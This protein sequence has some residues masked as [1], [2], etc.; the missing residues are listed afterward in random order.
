[1]EMSS[2]SAS[3]PHVCDH[4]DKRFKLAGDL[5]RH[6]ASVHDIGVV[7]HQCGQCDMRF[8]HASNLKRHLANAHDVGVVW[9]QCDQCDKP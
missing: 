6:L 5:K 8:K 2:P 1:M 9:H 7:W 4:C 3:R